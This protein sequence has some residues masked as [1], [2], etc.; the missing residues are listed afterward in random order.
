MFAKFS[1]DAARVGY[2]RGNNLYVEEIESGAV[3]ALTSDGSPTLINGTS[4]WVYEEELGLRD[5]F[6]WSPDGKS[7]AFWQFDSSGVE[8]FSLINNTDSLYPKITTVPYPKAGTKNSAVRVGVIPATGGAPVWIQ[9]PGDPRQNYL[10]RMNWTREGRLLVGQL[11]RRQ[12]DAGI[13]MADPATGAVREIFH[14]HDDAWADIPESE[15]V[16]SET[17]AFEWLD[18]ARS[19]LWLSERDGWRHAYAAPLAGG[20]PRLITHGA[21]DVMDFL[22][23][24]GKW[25]YFTAAGK[26]ATQR[27]LYRAPAEGGKPVL[28][29]PANR[30]GTNSYDISPDCKW[31]V[32]TWSRFDQPP[33]IELVS[34]P[35]HKVIRMLEENA[36]LHTAAAGIANPPVEFFQV[37]VAEGVSLDGYMIKP[38]DF[39][40][41]RKYPVIVHI[42]GEPA[43]TT[44]IDRWQ[45]ATGL[46]HRAL[47][48]EGYIVVSF[49]NRGTPAPKG[50]E[51]RKA[52]YGSVGVL[53]TQDQTNAVYA[54]ARQHSFI[55]LDRIGVW[56]WSGGGTNTLN[57]MFRSPDL[58]RVGVSVAPVPD[59]KL[60]DTIYQERYM[61]M[62]DENAAGYKAGSAIHFAG[63]LRGRLLVI[64]G[65]GDDNVHFQ[66]TEKLENR[67]IELGKPFD[68]MEYPN[69]THSISEGPGTTLH[70]YSLIARYFIEHLPAGAVASERSS[71]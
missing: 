30:T 41:A 13:F 9:M 1:P 63:G 24:D 61:G 56:G 42:Y 40:P 47:A 52:I 64:H 25:L 15:G 36:V 5:G 16:R 58:Y 29:T 50:R 35:D 19:F 57:L 37:P 48:A 17:E 33:T 20:T 71:R 62:P 3:K 26:N 70:I 39:D 60:Y 10:F 31:A 68:F 23:T 11:N 8:M 53:S 54:L 18:E 55:D 2:V 34:L 22:A 32:H 49:D 67:L 21:Q 7:I 44:V 43:S 69:R 27:Y 14:D 38:R 4:D 65:S 51:W 59:Q 66:G 6:R 45:G 12:S 28:V 46:F